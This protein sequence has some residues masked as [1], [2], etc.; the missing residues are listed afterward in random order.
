[1]TRAVLFLD[2]DRV[3]LPFQDTTAWPDYTV[4][5][6]PYGDVPM[7]PRLLAVVGALPARIVYVTDWQADAKLLDVHLGRADTEVAVRTAG[8]GWWKTRAIADYLTSNPDVKTFIHADD[9]LHEDRLAD[10]DRIADSRPHLTV[11]PVDGLTPAD[12][13]VMQRFLADG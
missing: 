6:S 5:D 9:H 3:L 2:I 1:M 13:A 12:V 7:S 8:N 10:L 4:I 11:V